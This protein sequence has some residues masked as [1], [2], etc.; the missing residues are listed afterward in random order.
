[1]VEGEVGTSFSSPKPPTCHPMSSTTEMPDT[2]PRSRVPGSLGRNPRFVGTPSPGQHL[3]TP[4]KPSA[5]HAS[6]HFP[7]SCTHLVFASPMFCLF[8]CFLCPEGRVGTDGCHPC[9]MWLALPLRQEA[10]CTLHRG[11]NSTGSGSRAA[12]Q[13]TWWGRKGVGM[14]ILGGRQGNTAVACPV[15]SQ[16]GSAWIP[17]ELVSACSVASP[18]TLC[19]SSNSG[20]QKAN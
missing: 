9:D 20:G 4:A 5:G 2:G 18:N 10:A 8:V 3:L 13:A 16:N 1:M 19:S 7:G 6:G 14:P 17:T 12:K 11:P 15:L